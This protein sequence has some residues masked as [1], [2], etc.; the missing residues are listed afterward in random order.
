MHLVT[1]V[2][3]TYQ[4]LSVHCA[5]YPF[6]LQLAWPYCCE[7]SAVHY[8]LSAHNC[9]TSYSIPFSALLHTVAVR[10]QNTTPA[11]RNW[12]LCITTAVQLWVNFERSPRTTVF[13]DVGSNF[14]FKYLPSVRWTKRHHTAHLPVSLHRTCIATVAYPT[15]LKFTLGNTIQFLTTVNIV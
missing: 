15:V 1:P 3:K 11:G 7:Q 10:W 8:T 14:S 9:T 12:F 6:V 2:P 4:Q 5:G 13:T